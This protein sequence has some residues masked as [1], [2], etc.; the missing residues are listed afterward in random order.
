MET[1]A[2]SV[3]TIPILIPGFAESTEVYVVCNKGVDDVAAEPVSHQ[4]SVEMAEAYDLAM[5]Q[6]SVDNQLPHTELAESTGAST[7]YWE[8][9]S[10]QSQ[11]TD[12]QGHLEENFLN[13]KECYTHIHQYWI[14]LRMATGCP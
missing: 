11:I 4:G 9:E 13:W 8:V 1:G 6:A 14:V 2:G 10:A 12:I 7:K 3:D 5:S